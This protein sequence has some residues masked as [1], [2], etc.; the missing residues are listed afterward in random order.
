MERRKIVILTIGAALAGAVLLLTFLSRTV[1][2]MRLPGVEAGFIVGGNITRS[3]QAEGHADFAGRLGIYSDVP[4]RIE[5]A[6]RQGDRV[7][8]GDLLFTIYTDI[9]TGAPVY[10]DVYGVVRQFPHGLESG[11]QVG[12]NYLVMSLGL[13]QDRQYTVTVYFPERMGFLAIGSPAEVSIPS[14][15]AHGLSG[16]ITHIIAVYDRLRTEITFEFPPDFVGARVTGGERTEVVITRLYMEREQILPNTA[17][18]EGKFGYYVLAV[19]GERHAFMGYSYYVEPVE[20]T[21]WVRGDGYSS[22]S[23]DSGSVRGPV[24]FFSDRPLYAG[25]R[26]RLV[27]DGGG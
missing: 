19:V 9:N 16:H 25:D 8:P 21:V 22:V 27:G 26:V 18:R 3:F 11:M 15:R 23:V 12:R 7:A 10:A 6:V 2:T 20:I 13:C 14:R 17:I 24:V 5:Y 1:F 4:G